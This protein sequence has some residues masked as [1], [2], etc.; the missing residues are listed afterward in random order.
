[1]KRS[2]RVLALLLMLVM[3]VSALTVGVSAAYSPLSRSSG[4]YYYLTLS[5]Y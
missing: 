2:T 4:S 3:L 1:M 5:G